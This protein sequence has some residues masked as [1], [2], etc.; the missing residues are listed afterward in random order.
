MNLG[1]N[2]LNN[3]QGGASSSPT[4]SFSRDSGNGIFGE[5]RPQLKSVSNNFDFNNNN[6]DRFDKYGGSSS[7]GNSEYGGGLL[8]A[9]SRSQ[10][11]SIL[12]TLMGS[13]LGEKFK[14]C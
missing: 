4:S 10:P 12:D 7:I 5:V 11:R 14:I 2:I 13:F 9:G 1:G 8:G 3:A 6:Y